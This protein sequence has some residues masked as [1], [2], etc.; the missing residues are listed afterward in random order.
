[1]NILNVTRLFSCDIENTEKQNCFFFYASS[2][3]ADR[4]LNGIFNVFYLL[5][6]FYLKLTL[7]LRN[8]DISYLRK[9][10]LNQVC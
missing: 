8:Q 4:F 5:F 1:M 3:R 6:F 2:R 7:L 9:K 10:I